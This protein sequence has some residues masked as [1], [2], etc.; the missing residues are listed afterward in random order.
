MNVLSCLRL[1]EQCVDILISVHREIFEAG[2][3]LVE[4]LATPI[5]K[6]EGYVFCV[7]LLQPASHISSLGL[8]NIFTTF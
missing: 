1:T 6:L 2:D 3:V 8:W 7:S 5:L 4:E